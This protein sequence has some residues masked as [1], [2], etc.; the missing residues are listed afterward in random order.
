[1]IPTVR[2][3]DPLF[4]LPILRADNN[5]R[6][7]WVHVNARAQWQRG[8]GWQ[9]NLY[10]GVQTGGNNWAA[11]FVPVSELKVTDLNAALWSY[12]LTAAQTFGV[13]I[14]IWVHDPNNFAKRAEITQLGNVAGLGKTLGLNAHTL[15]KTV[16][17]FFW[18]GE[19]WSTGEAVALTGSGLTSGP[20]NLY[21]W[22]QFQADALFSTW[23]IYRISL[24]YGW[25]ASGTFDNVWVVEL[26]LNGYMV[27]IRPS[28]EEMLEM[29]RGSGAVYIKVDAA[30]A[31]TAR[32][33][34]TSVKRL[35]DAYLLVTVQDQKFGDSASQTYTVAADASINFRH[36]DIS[37]LYFKNATGGQNGTVTILGTE[38]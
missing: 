16:A 1:M 37:T 32:R 28:V 15:D 36:I 21:T 4:A 11:M 24:E 14:V 27:P 22:A 33:F 10:G 2:I 19:D 20:G 35:R 5:G 34:E 18:N 9:A 38:E 13:N 17:Q 3:L 6:A 26:K 30:G 7:T 23:H 12:R 8:T 31:D 25:E 29:L